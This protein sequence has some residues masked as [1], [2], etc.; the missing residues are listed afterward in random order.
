MLP[1]ATLHPILSGEDFIGTSESYDF[2]LEKS[3][4]QAEYKIG[5]FGIGVDGH[6]AGILPKCEALDSLTYVYGYHTPSFDRITMTKKAILL[7]DEAVVFTQ[8]DEKWKVIEV[9]GRKVVKKG[10]AKVQR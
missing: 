9:V 10:K 4:S 3:L 6:T 2:T 8:G 7:L 1:E 5:L